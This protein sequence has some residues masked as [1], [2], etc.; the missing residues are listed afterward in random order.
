MENKFDRKS[1]TINRR[2][3]LGGTLSAA[4]IIAGCLSGFSGNAAVHQNRSAAVRNSFN[5]MKE[6]MRYRKIDAYGNAYALNPALA[7]SQIEYADKLGIEKLFIAV[8]VA[9]KMAKTPDEFREYN[10]QVLK[11]MKQYPDRLIGQLTI[12]PA[13][14]KESFEEIKRCIDQGMIGMKLYN[15]VKIN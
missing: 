3:F 13:Y 10:N 9:V 12:H 4:G 7:K 14:P 1:Y 8:P 6:V 5:I 15:Q 11:A 2:A